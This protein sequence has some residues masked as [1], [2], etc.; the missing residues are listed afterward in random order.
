MMLLPN[1]PRLLARLLPARKAPIQPAQWEADVLKAWQEGVE[2]SALLLDH[3]AN[4]AEARQDPAAYA[5]ASCAASTLR[6][7]KTCG[8]LNR[9]A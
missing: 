8:P 5:E 7:L 9:P 1:L 2:Y 6:V 4:A 3:R